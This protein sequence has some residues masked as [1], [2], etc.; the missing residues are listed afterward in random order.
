[1]SYR[2][3]TVVTIVTFRFYVRDY[4]IHMTLKVRRCTGSPPHR[5]LK[6][7]MEPSHDHP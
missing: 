5:P 6:D 1:M 2:P 4:N 7:W 3:T